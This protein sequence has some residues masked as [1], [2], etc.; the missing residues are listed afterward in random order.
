MGQKITLK[1]RKITLIAAMTKF[2]GGKLISNN[3]Y[4]K[5]LRKNLRDDKPG[6]NLILILG[7]VPS[8]NSQSFF[9][10]GVSFSSHPDA[11]TSRI[12]NLDSGKVDLVP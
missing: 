6:T 7:V 5:E 1:S 3:G 2:F 9:L 12:L 4:F 8:L 11:C 10:L